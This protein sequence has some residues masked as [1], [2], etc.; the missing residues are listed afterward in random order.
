M[1]SSS[2]VHAEVDQASARR[3][4]DVT[5]GQHVGR[6]LG[7]ADQDLVAGLQVGAPPGVGD[8]VQSFRRSA[9]E[10][11]LE[12]ITRTDERSNGGASAF[13]RRTRPPGEGMQGR[14]RVG[15][16]V[17]VEGR[18]RVDHR[19]RT[20][21]RRRGVQVG[22][23]FAVD[24][25]RESRECRSP[26]F[27]KSLARGTC[28]HARVAGDRRN[29]H[30]PEKVP[31]HHCRLRWRVVAKGTAL[32]RGSHGVGGN[33]HIPHTVV[34]SA[35]EGRKTRFP[36]PS[37]SRASSRGYSRREQGREKSVNGSVKNPVG[38][39]LTEALPPGPQWRLRRRPRTGMTTS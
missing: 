8:E 18:D 6:M 4:R 35:N 31:P 16:V 28:H 5:P 24:F 39:S 1:R 32:L 13:Q 2:R 12:R 15:V 23:R 19:S 7:H 37:D 34:L 9:G 30:L 33:P 10:D 27:L 26:R 21:R 36:S 25:L 20:K 22:E 3:L 14:P 38:Q 11:H 17:R 29:R